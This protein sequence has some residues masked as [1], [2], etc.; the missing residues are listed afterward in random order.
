MGE[1]SFIV[2]VS[3]LMNIDEMSLE[4][5]WQQI[6][7][8]ANEHPELIAVMDATYSFQLTGEDGVNYVISFTGDSVS[9]V[10]YGIDNADCIIILSIENFKKLIHGNINSASACMTGRVK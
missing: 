1:Q 3:K 7:E 5:I 10:K 6:E 2:E 8:R 9:V 4:E